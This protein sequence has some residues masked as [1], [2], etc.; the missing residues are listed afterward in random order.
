MEFE[1]ENENSGKNYILMKFILD[2][3][4]FIDSYHSWHL[5]LSLFLSLSFLNV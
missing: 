3:F 4:P 1:P 2:L 5:S